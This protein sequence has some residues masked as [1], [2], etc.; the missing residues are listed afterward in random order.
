MTCNYCFWE[1][2]KTLTTNATRLR[3]HLINNCTL[4]PDDV[5]ERLSEETKKVFPVYCG[6]LTDSLRSLVVK[7]VEQTS[8]RAKRKVSYVEDDE[9]DSISDSRSQ[10][11]GSESGSRTPKGRLD[12]ENAKLTSQLK[13]CQKQ[14]EALLQIN[15][16][17]DRS[18]LIMEK[19][20][21]FYVNAIGASEDQNVAELNI[22]LNS[23]N[24]SVK[25]WK[26]KYNLL[27][28][29]D[30][31][32]K[33]F[34]LPGWTLAFSLYRLKA[35]FSLAVSVTNQ[36]PTTHRPQSTIWKYFITVGEDSAGYKTI[37]CMFC[38]K[39]FRH[40]QLNATKCRTHIVEN[41]QYCPSDVREQENNWI[42]YHPQSKIDIWQHFSVSEENYKI[43]VTC[44]YCG[45]VYMGKNATKCRG[46]L[47]GKCEHVPDEVR[48]A[49]A[50]KC[51][52]AFVNNSQV[53][54]KTKMS[55]IWKY[56]DV[57]SDAG[58][59]VVSLSY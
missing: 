47:V 59:A 49:I 21:E 57:Q 24:E 13:I 27:E 41:C 45:S 3:Q 34:K 16:Y 9:D 38:Q 50:D 4:T 33:M 18:L 10:N 43:T 54:V 6:S 19:L 30:R 25:E 58:T 14:K 37:K 2:G 55:K 32:K 22:Q 26:K 7:P 53:S 36:S 52:D 42:E 8:F 35:L 11:S 44:M 12:E 1:M 39:M 31:M 56:F 17:L 48:E 5:K 46:H 29:D 40:K 23:S 51:D 15:K 28:F 20:N